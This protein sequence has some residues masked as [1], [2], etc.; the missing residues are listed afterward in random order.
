MYDWMLEGESFLLACAH[1][2]QWLS[3]RQ[4]FFFLENAW[5]LGKCICSCLQFFLCR[6]CSGK[7]TSGLNEIYCLSQNLMWTI[8]SQS[9]TGLVLNL[10]HLLPSFPS[11]VTLEDKFSWLYSHQ[12]I[13]AGTDHILQNIAN[14]WGVCKQYPWL[15]S[16]QLPD[17]ATQNPMIAQEDKEDSHS[18]ASWFQNYLQAY[19]I[20]K[21]LAAAHSFR[22]PT[23][24]CF[25]NP[26]AWKNELLA[27]SRVTIQVAKMRI[28]NEPSCSQGQRVGYSKSSIVSLI[29]YGQCN[30]FELCN[31]QW[32]NGEVS[33]I[34]QFCQ[35]RGWG[36]NKCCPC[37]YPGKLHYSTRE[38][39]PSSINGLIV[40][41]GVWDCK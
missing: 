10:V 4:V 18:F 25:S 12:S 28:M 24:T 9:S 35:S 1:K 29:P 26:F 16:L 23:G 36:W 6:A 31:S 40:I 15:K 34:L 39:S 20:K 5:R 19:L 14:F 11:P 21:A 22:E 7:I 32:S 8:S 27:C 13:P 30:K 41:P 3:P 38:L 37:K 2:L 33:L 17:N